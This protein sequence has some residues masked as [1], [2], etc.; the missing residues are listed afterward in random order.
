MATM[1]VAPFVVPAPTTGVELEPYTNEE[2]GLRGLVP[3]GWSE[4]QPGI[5]ARG[6]PAADM[7]VLQVA[8]E[9][10]MGTQALL[11]V[12]AE[13]Y[14]LDGPPEPAGERSANDMTWSLYA[15]QVQGVPRDLALA[16]SEAGTLIVVLR[17]AAEERDVLYESVFLPV[18]DA[19]DLIE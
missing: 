2:M 12:M 18:V 7:A 15:F 19:L 5:L 16:E 1:E 10:S 14:G 4:L 17:S 6:N 13:G 8:V 3:T 11:E 9:A